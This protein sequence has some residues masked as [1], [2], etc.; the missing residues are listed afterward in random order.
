MKVLVTGATGFIGSKLVPRL[1]AAGNE[2][3]TLGRG[4]A[5]TE[6]LASLP[7]EHVRG[8]ITDPQAVA[9]AVAGCDV[10][11]HLA[12]LVSYRKSAREYQY[13]VNVAGTRNVMEA[14]LAAGVGRVIHTSSIA[15]MGIPAPG[16]TGT[17][18]M[19]YNLEGLGLNYCD[20]KHE[21]E[22]EVLKC[23][24]R[25]LPALILSPGIILGE[26]DTH[27]HHRTIF[28]AISR[29]WLV[30]CPAGGVTFC[31][32]EDVVGAHVNALTMGRPGERYVLGSANLTYREA[33]A[34]A[35]SVLGCRVPTFTL[36]GWLIE[37]LG[38]ACEAIFPLF[39]RKPSLT[40]QIAWLSQH[41]IFF[42][43]EKAIRELQMQVTP[44]EQTV[45]RTA[46]YYLAGAY[47]FG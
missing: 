19:P 21:G 11:F 35:S 44:F 39:G 41:C 12:G 38:S 9:T 26:G 25:G 6:E 40:R 27:P 24:E 47:V 37:P 20:S 1:V 30:G 33:G 10:V 31:D 13:Q 29:G 43:N 32:I 45:R 36:P 22:L 34:I 3:R 2:V 5:L 23:V 46:P 4:A 7:V 18:E 15:G 16:T 14:A 42:S 28:L 8:D 17:E